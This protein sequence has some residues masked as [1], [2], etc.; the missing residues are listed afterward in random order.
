MFADREA[1]GGILVGPDVAPAVEPAQLGIPGAGQRRQFDTLGDL[2]APAV[3]DA[4]DATR[5]QRAGADLVEVAELARLER[6]A[7]A[8]SLYNIGPIFGVSPRRRTNAGLETYQLSN[9]R[10]QRTWWL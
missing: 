10:A 1:L 3:D 9:L 6:A 7:S 8:D 5:L 2:G 4:E